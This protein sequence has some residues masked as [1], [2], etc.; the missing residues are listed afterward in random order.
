MKS[1][2]KTS[3][4]G[5]WLK[6]RVPVIILLLVSLVVALLSGLISA[7]VNSAYLKNH[8]LYG[9]TAAYYYLQCVAYLDSKFMGKWEA[10]KNQFF[11]NSRNPFRL[12]PI[13]WMNPDWLI[14][15]NGHLITTSLMLFAYLF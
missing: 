11:E 15:H 2:M 5:F 8:S 10:I 7:T 13:I 3:G 9:D 6:K 1:E 12:I 4:I 14:E